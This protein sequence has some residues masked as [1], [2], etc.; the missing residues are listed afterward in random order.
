MIDTV[1]KKLEG[2][3]FVQIEFVTRLREEGTDN[4]NHLLDGIKASK[5]GVSFPRIP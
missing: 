5:Q 2:E 3:P 1:V 4:F